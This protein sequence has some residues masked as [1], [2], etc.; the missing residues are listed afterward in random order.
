MAASWQQRPLDHL[1]KCVSKDHQIVTTSV[2]TRHQGPLDH[3]YKCVKDHQTIATS[4]S[5]KTIRPLLQVCH[6]RPWLQQCHQRPQ[7]IATSMLARVT[8]PFLQ[9]L[10]GCDFGPLQHLQGLVDLS[11]SWAGR[12]LLLLCPQGFGFGPLHRLQ[13]LL[14]LSCSYLQKDVGRNHQTLAVCVCVCV[15]VRTTRPPLSIFFKLCWQL[16]LSPC[17]N[18]QQKPHPLLHSA[19]S[20]FAFRLIHFCIHFC[21]QPGPLLHPRLHSLLHSVSS[22]Y[23]SQSIITTCNQ[24]TES[25][26][27]LQLSNIKYNSQSQSAIIFYSCRPKFRMILTD[28]LNRYFSGWTENVHHIK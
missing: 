20:T 28:L 2:T 26:S 13:G 25:I 18:L 23:S 9:L 4:V 12:P 21:I 22:I 16:L 8:R 1:Y 11:F 19:S 7:T 15:C 24:T 5:A 3:G 6:Q 17:L 14:D 27:T 10:Q